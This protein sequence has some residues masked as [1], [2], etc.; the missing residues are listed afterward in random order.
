MRGKIHWFSVRAEGL[1][2]VEREVRDATPFPNFPLVVA[3]VLLIMG[4]RRPEAPWDAANLRG[5]YYRKADL[6]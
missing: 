3:C 4:P 2:P 5:P 1:V 6:R